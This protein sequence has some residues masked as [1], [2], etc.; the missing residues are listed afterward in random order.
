MFVKNGAVRIFYEIEGGG[1]PLILHT[2]GGGD[3]RIWKYA[4]YTEAL[5][6]FTK[7][8]IDQRG[9]GKSDRPSTIQS[10]KMEE[11]VSDICAVLDDANVESAGFWGYSA[12][13][14]VG[15]AF[16]SMHQNRL[17]ALVGTGSLP[18]VN[19][20]DLQKPADIAAE[21]RKD[22]EA[23]G[24]KAELEKYMKNDNDRFPDAIHNNVL[25]GDPL[26]YALDDVAWYEWN[27][28]LNAYAQ[29][30]APV[31]MISGQLEDPDHQTEESIKR[32]PKGR[33][34]RIPGIG[35]LS[36]F[37]RSDLTLPHVL[38]FLDVAMRP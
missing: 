22:V 4:G 3:L 1:P 11:F 25:E 8:M 20:S 37:Y 19:F 29:L 27:G 38:P 31:M 18:F 12:G 10:H 21:I 9:R 2:G 13:A 5:S 35:H 24:V 33:L 30:Q 34:A 36:A 23:G 14:L 26:M 7:I 6:G 32:I 28:P 17:R 16:G 15:V